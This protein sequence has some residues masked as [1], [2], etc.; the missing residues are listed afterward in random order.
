MAE[1]SD[2]IFA[3]GGGGVLED[4]GDSFY[5]YR[6]SDDNWEPLEPI[7]CPVGYNVGNRLGLC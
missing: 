1:Q 5:R 7:P 3:L 4:P 6:I 2:Y